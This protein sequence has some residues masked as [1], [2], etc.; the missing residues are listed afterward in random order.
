MSACGLGITCTDTTSPSLDAASAPLSV[1]AFTAPT[2]PC[3][4]TVTRP[5]PIFSVPTNSTS[6]DLSIASAASIDATSPLVSIIPTA[7][8]ISSSWFLVSEF[9]WFVLH[10]PALPE[11]ALLPVPH[12]QIFRP[13]QLS[14]LPERFVLAQR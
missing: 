6:A 12:Q 9:D 1:A 8:M 10:Y 14:L 13:G 4:I 5:Q 2:S 3:T 11:A 7:F